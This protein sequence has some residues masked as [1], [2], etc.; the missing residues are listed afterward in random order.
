MALA[1]FVGES[2]GG[3][4]LLPKQFHCVAFLGVKVEFNAISQIVV[5]MSI[6]KIATSVLGFRDRISNMLDPIFQSAIEHWCRVK[7]LLG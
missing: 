2:A 4:N 6:F 1:L 3:D 7:P 5:R